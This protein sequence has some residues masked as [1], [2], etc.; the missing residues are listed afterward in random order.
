MTTLRVLI[1]SID[2]AD[3]VP[4]PPQTMRGQHEIERRRLSCNDIRDLLRREHDAR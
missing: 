2:N 3:A 4:L 1:A